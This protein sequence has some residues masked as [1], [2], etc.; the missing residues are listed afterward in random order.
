MRVER[1]AT[2]GLRLG[3]GHGGRPGRGQG[4]SSASGGFHADTCPL[5]ASH[6]HSCTPPRP[7]PCLVP[8]II[9][10]AGGES[11]SPEPLENMVKKKIPVVSHAMLV[12]D[13]A[14]FLGALLTL[15]VTGAPGPAGACVP[16]G[17]VTGVS[18][19]SVRWT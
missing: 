7:K 10:M 1:P 18:R 13:K 6:Y 2:R 3:D 4:S 19:R 9:T 11:V 5:W 17:V 12:G 16:V 14:K 8:E 15:K